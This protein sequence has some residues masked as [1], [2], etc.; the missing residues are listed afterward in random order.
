MF[1]AERLSTPGENSVTRQ[2]RIF[3]RNVLLLLV[4]LG[5][6]LWSSP[7]RCQGADIDAL[8]QMVDS[9]RARGDFAAATAKVQQFEAE[10]KTYQGSRS[11]YG[12]RLI[13]LG[14]MH[15]SLGNYAEAER[16]YKEAI[17]ILEKAKGPTHHN[18]GSATASLAN[19]YFSQGR[20]E[21]AEE[22][23]RRALVIAEKSLV[24]ND[25]HVV[26]PV[27]HNL[28]TLYY[29]Q[30]RFDSAKA[31]LRRAL[32]I[33]EAAG[34]TSRL[35]AATVLGT[36]ANVSIGQDQLDEGK[37]L[38]TR[39]LE[40]H[41]KALGPG[42]P[43][44]AFD[45]VRLATIENLRRRY[46]LEEPV[47]KRVLSIRERS[48][49]PDHPALAAAFARLAENHAHQHRYGAAVPLYGRALTIQ[50]KAL[51]LTHPETIRTMDDFAQLAAVQGQWFGALHWSRRVTSA[52]AV[53]D[54][55]ISYTERRGNE[56]TIVT[57]V[58]GYFRRHVEHLAAAARKGI[59]PAPSLG[60]EAVEIAQ[61]V[62]QST[63][64][65]ALQRMAVR[66]ASE[67]NA[68]G[69]LVRESQD[70][71]ASRQH[72]DNALIAAVSKPASQ[73][74]QMLIDN[75][76][77]EIGENE[78]RLA[79][80]N[81]RLEDGLPDYA[82]LS[83]PKPLSAD[84]IQRLLGADEVFIFW[85]KNLV[86][87]LTR[88]RF[89]W[90][91]LEGTTSLP[92]LVE[93][94]MRPFRTM[95]YPAI[96]TDAATTGPGG[97]APKGARGLADEDRSEPLAG[98][99]A[100]GEFDLAASH[101]LYRALFGPIEELIKEKEHLIIVADGVLTGLPFQLLIKQAPGAG[102][103]F[104]TAHW[105]IRD[106][107]VSVLP[108]VSSLRALRGIPRRTQAAS[109]PFIGFGDPLVG[110]NA[111]TTS[112]AGF[113]PDDLKDK[114][115]EMAGAS[116][117]LTR[118][119][120]IDPQMFSGGGFTDQ[121]IAI[122]DVNW[123]REHASRLPE[124]RCEIEALARLRG[125]GST[126]HAGEQATETKVKEL[127]RKG[128]LRK[129]R[130]LAFATHGLLPEQAK[131]VA[132]AGLVLT[133]PAKGSAEDDGLLTASEV[134]GLDLDADWVMLSACNTASGD[135]PGAATLSGLARAFFYA[136]AR[137]LLVSH[138]PVD[139]RAAVLL[140]TRTLRAMEQDASL[141]KAQALRRAM[142]SFLNDGVPD[143]W[144]NPRVWAPFSLIGEG[145]R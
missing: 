59:E 141:G 128:E 62:S 67:N 102:T 69:A 86:F 56:D 136:G 118:A 129:Y 4:T 97:N 21:M 15:W 58:T 121:G 111:G 75:I 19:V 46:D 24:P 64:A 77:R 54:R 26:G 34:D 139:S 66:F 116:T 134:A 143:A 13:Y 140:T 82:A 95:P 73:R 7:L 119:P 8:E 17:P 48:L 74:N 11:D 110:S 23:F 85:Q 114:P 130:M 35:D 93:L 106:H 41:E 124:S 33:F 109:L 28:G 42:H 135:K 99:R 25:P 79:A 112:C 1:R 126:I 53:R 39:A 132:E 63:A 107:A 144:S 127:S 50:E 122:A 101:E 94:S 133:P 5:T 44:V 105:L 57:S 36:L 31:L 30:E 9:L 45:L 68:I 103:T 61:R 92:R 71:T 47:R 40:I 60:R 51:G 88:D 16:L 27:L 14:R 90:R 89:D 83:H 108:A 96:I 145:A 52:L 65:G 22:F 3:M 131:G 55:E 12:I 142:L 120:A 6:L 37:Q 81:T 38:A 29:Y 87:A 104:K 84:E 91:P 49:P 125:A 80:N 113:E 123:L 98:R 32:A 117:S 137:S 70:L 100:T 72:Y 18:V 20:Y 43:T 10:T 76:R 78:G 2:T 115:V 138:W